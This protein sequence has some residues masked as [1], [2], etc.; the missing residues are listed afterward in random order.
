MRKKIYNEKSLD[1]LLDSSVTARHS[2]RT[3]TCVV[4]IS[5]QQCALIN[6]AEASAWGGGEGLWNMPEFM[7]KSIN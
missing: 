7:M 1:F 4:M 5:Q 2:R 6:K 3:V